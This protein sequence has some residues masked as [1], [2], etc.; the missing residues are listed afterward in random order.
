MTQSA[1]QW[2]AQLE[3]D[4][5]THTARVQ[6]MLE[7]GR[8]AA[9]RAA[10]LETLNAGSV[11]ARLMAMY[12]GF[13]S[14]DSAL[15]LRGLGDAATVV[16][17]VAV[18]LVPLALSD[19]QFQTLLPTLPKR[20]LRAVL[21][22]WKRA[23]RSSAPVDAALEASSDPRWQTVLLPFASEA[24]AQRHIALLEAAFVHDWQRVARAHPNTVLERLQAML[25]AARGF[26]PRLIW[27]LNAVL[28]ALA[29]AVPD[30]ALTLL[31]LAL[32]HA[33]IGQLNPQAL[34][35]CR[36]QA[37][38]ALEVQSAD[39]SR[40]NWQRRAH[41][42][43]ADTLDAL[44]ERHAGTLTD[45]TYTLRRLPPA[46][47]R[48]LYTRFAAGWRDKDG[49]IPLAWLRFLPADLRERE[50][51]HHLALPALATR[52]AQR[53]PYASLLSWV[54]ANAFLEPFIKH[55]DPQLRQLAAAALL[56]AVRFDRASAAQAL[57]FALQR[58]NEQDPVRMV[59]LEGLAALPVATWQTE[60]LKDL[61]QVIRDALDA[62]DLSYMTATHAQALVGR[63][64]PFHTAWAVE[65][66]AT[67]VKERGS[68]NLYGLG[69]RMD[70]AAAQRL[71]GALLPVLRS[72]FSQQREGFI[73]QALSAFG[74]RLR[75]LEKF[76]NL[77]EQLVSSAAY[78]GTSG[79]ALAL[80]R[81]YQ[82][83]RFAKLAPALLKKDESWILDHSVLYHV[84]RHHQNLLTPFI[85]GKVL[86][87]RFAHG[88]RARSILPL[89]KGFHRW[90]PAQQLLF[91]QTLEAI[92][93]DKRDMPSLF[94]VVQQLAAIPE[95]SPNRIAEIAQ[96]GKMIHA[97]LRDTAL[98]ALARLEE[99][100]GVPFLLEAMNDDRARIAIYA[101][102][103]ALT[104]MPAARALETLQ[105]MPL[106]KVT[107]AK[108][109][110]RLIGELRTPEARTELLL[111]S[112][113]N[114]HRDVRVS[115][116]RAL[117]DHLESADTWT[118]FN[119]AAVSSDPA[120]ADGV[121]R[122]PAQAL[123]PDAQS[124]L[125]A[126]LGVLLAHPDLRVRTETL[127]R[128][129]S[130]PI[131]DRERTLLP[132]LLERLNSA[133][134]DETRLA[135]SALFAT[136]SSGDS[137]GFASAV[138]A[139]LPNRPAL[140]ITLEV[141]GT[142]LHWQRERAQDLTRATLRALE[143]DGITATLRAVL[144]LEGLPWSEAA[145]ALKQ[146][147]AAGQLHPESLMRA[148]A[149]VGTVQRTDRA[150]LS[151][152]ERDLRDDPSPNLRRIA[153]A[154]LLSTGRKWTA[155]RLERLDAYRRD[156]SLLVAA[157][158]QFHD[159]TRPPPE[160]D[161]DSD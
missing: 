23:G 128:L 40:I 68:I 29:D 41:R 62:A 132:K 88:H 101:L 73:V 83:Q 36:P 145:A 127:S 106:E 87:G 153:L 93:G 90:T 96:G 10:L 126:L 143:P 57:R 74:P 135:A 38:A 52:P 32:R 53:L 111:R 47:R 95:A 33:A 78:P 133:Y 5:P 18:K 113:Q 27:Q 114:L 117:W 80:L 125:V 161:P 85:P 109:V 119:E 7:I 138:T 50:A 81:R 34:A 140:R 6:R 46:R 103:R 91:A 2:M 150:Q 89:Y 55:P 155:T 147:E 11:S 61:G 116:L 67:L 131:T 12:T 158:A 66:L 79:Q 76:A 107:V 28:P 20:Q 123:A 16:R 72:W 31:P 148:V 26:E 82:R 25:G 97:A 45:L 22:L 84:H 151:T 56:G 139:I 8:Q 121:I 98:R 108:E 1:Q 48:D 49:A 37:V 137:A 130:L 4:A 134:P 13:T 39:R 63:L 144:S 154:A 54:D 102:R 122:I 115:V 75:A 160:D 65:W 35:E 156:P 94:N 77:L 99:G 42:L 21:S 43:E 129:E 142:H 141:L 58:K 3:R 100:K 64:L 124:R 86:R 14:R 92:T 9:E 51:R 146:L 44:L 17:S 15:V 30:A 60:H 69:W 110:V 105:K 112:R 152:L 157:A 59:M 136:Y 104:E 71:E 24:C 149:T 120:I 118:V 159:P 19:A 70:D